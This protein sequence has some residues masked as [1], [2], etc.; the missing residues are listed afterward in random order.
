MYAYV[1]D[2][3]VYVYIY[4]YKTHIYVNDPIENLQIEHLNAEKL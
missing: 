2:M 1:C 3:C 4:V